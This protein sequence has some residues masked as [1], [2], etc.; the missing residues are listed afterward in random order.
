M[1]LRFHSC[2]DTLDILKIR[3]T[4]GAKNNEALETVLISLASIVVLAGTPKRRLVDS[5]FYDCPVRSV[6]PNIGG[7]QFEGGDHGWD[8]NP[9][10]C[11]M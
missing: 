1:I 3:Y 10:L 7:G 5:R 11:E 9:V 4:L 8:K 2:H 6:L